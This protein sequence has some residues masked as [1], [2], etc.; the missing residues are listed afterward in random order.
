M[1]CP[2]CASPFVR[3]RVHGFDAECECVDCASSWLESGSSTLDITPGL[4]EGR[5]AELASTWDEQRRLR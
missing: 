1:S 2:T 4:R 3:V 5:V